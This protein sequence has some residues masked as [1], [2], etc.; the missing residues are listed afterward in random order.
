ML[1]RVDQ[2]AVRTRARKMADLIRVLVVGA[3]GK[4]GQTVCRAVMDDEALELVAAVDTVGREA[5]VLSGS[6]LSLES[7][8]NRALDSSSPDVMVD[9]TTAG[10]VMNNASAA[11]ARGAHCVI[12]TTGL[13]RDEL[14]D[15]GEL[16]KNSGRNIIFA[17]NFAIGAVLMM[18]MSEKIAKYFD[19]AEIVEYHHD[20]KR[21]APSGTAVLTAEIIGGQ[22][23]PEELDEEEKYSGARG[24]RV[25]NIPVH[26]VRLPG[27]VAH[28]EVIFG[29]QGQSLRIRHDSID[30]SSFM[31]GVVMAVKEIANRPDFTY[32]LDKLIEL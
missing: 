24:A 11:V 17:P 29:L 18:K 31:P 12:G 5:E 9:F 23:R 26:S 14:G 4:M 16:A 3:G 6:G 13:S 15:L 19:R 22:L 8:L 27:H 7:D 20:E 25:R 32:G 1:C 21:D 2:V 28:Q 10:A 30:R